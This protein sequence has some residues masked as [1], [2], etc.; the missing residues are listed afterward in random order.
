MSKSGQKEV[1]LE[2]NLPQVGGYRMFFNRFRIEREPGVR[3]VQFGFFVST[4]LIDSFSCSI[5]DPVLVEHKKRLLEYLALIGPGIKDEEKIPWKGCPVRNS[6]VVD[7]INM[8][9]RA[10]TCEIGLHGLN[11]HTASIASRAATPTVINAEALACLRSEPYLQKQ[12]IAA[13]YEEE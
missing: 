8:A 10:K 13:L 4:D 12:I 3:F 5:P 1:T 6:P 2:V 7:V 9:H 11:M